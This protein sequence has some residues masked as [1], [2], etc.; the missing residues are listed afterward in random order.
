M[1]YETKL[2]VGKVCKG[3]DEAGAVFFMIYAQVDLS[4][5]GSYSHVSKL[6]A[7]HKGNPTVY[8]YFDG[9]TRETE[10]GYGDKPI[11]LPI[12]TVLEALQKDVKTDDYRRFKWAMALL[13]AMK[14]DKEQLSVLLYGH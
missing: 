6:A 11:P 7:H 3:I 4:K 9:N 1:G 2:L 12:G 14:D 5:T 10:D 8:W 13:E